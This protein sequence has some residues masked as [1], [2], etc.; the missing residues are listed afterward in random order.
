MLLFI[1]KQPNLKLSLICFHETERQ[2][3]KN[4]LN[5]KESALAAG[6]TEKAAQSR[7][8]VLL[9]RERVQKRIR[10]KLQK[11]LKDSE[12]NPEYVLRGLRE[13]F[14]RCMQYS[15]IIDPLTGL[16]TGTFKFEPHAALKALE[17]M[18]R[19]FGMFS[20]D[21]TVNLNI[22]LDV[23]LNK[24]RQRAL[25]GIKPAAEIKDITA[26]ARDINALYSSA[27]A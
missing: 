5:A 8:T 9:K 1:E 18:G 10:E 22:G 26:E 13:I 17:L 20:A 3:I 2:T 24:A 19:N 7:A 15:E 16:G 6:Y 25:E 23:K 12:L 27:L 14:E 4:K 21:V 11:A